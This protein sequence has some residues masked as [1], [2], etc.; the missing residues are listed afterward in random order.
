MDTNGARLD[1]QRAAIGAAKAAGVERIAYTSVTRPTALNP[2]VVVPDHL[3][4]EEHLRV[5]GVEWIMLR[6]NAT[7]TCR[8]TRSG[9]RHRPGSS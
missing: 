8:S 9:D 7:Q 6:N 2:E 4:T 3:G 1:Q 5:S